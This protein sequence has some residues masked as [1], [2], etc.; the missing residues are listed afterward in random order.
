[1][2]KAAVIQAQPS[3]L[4][5]NSAPRN[6]HNPNENCRIASLTPGPG[7]YLLSDDTAELGKRGA[8]DLLGFE[9]ALTNR[10]KQVQRVSL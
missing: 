6:H 10:S 9:H 8:L 2:I 5:R 3:K 7:Y 1:M 4:Y